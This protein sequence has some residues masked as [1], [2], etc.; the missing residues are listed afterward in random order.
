MQPGMSVS[1]KM[2]HARSPARP[3][4]SD[5]YRKSVPCHGESWRVRGRRIGSSSGLNSERCQAKSMSTL[6]KTIEP[7]A[8]S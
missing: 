5:T 1:G 4:R 3:L 6:N 7:S 2:D 8:T